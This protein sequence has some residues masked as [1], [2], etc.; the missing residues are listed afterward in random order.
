MEED[1]LIAVNNGQLGLPIWSK[2]KILTYSL[3]YLT[4]G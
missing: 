2:R 1:E 3:P 4:F